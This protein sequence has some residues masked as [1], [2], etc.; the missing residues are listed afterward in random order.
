MIASRQL[1]LALPAFG[2]FGGSVLRPPSKRLLYIGQRW[3][4]DF[5]LEFANAAIHEVVIPRL[6][7]WT[8]RLNERFVAA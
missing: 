8:S 1:D 5:D 7:G 4:G 2:L 3:L 6:L